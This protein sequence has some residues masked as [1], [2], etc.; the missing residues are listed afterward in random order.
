[1]CDCNQVL[2]KKKYDIDTGMGT[3]E[4]TIA[5]TY[6]DRGYIRLGYIDDMSCLDHSENFKVNYCP[7]CGI[8]I[9]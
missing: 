1:M 2:I 5:V 8:K 3:F 6:D 9:Q 7:F 4:E